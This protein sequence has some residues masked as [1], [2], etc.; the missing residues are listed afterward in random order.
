MT[1]NTSRMVLRLAGLMALGLS[2]AGCGMIGGKKEQTAS[3]SFVQVDAD[4]LECL[5]RAM[6]FESHRS[7]RDGLVA[8][9]NVVMN[10][11][12][13]DAYPDTI[14]GVVGQK[15]QFA[16]GVMTRPMTSSGLPTV[17]EAAISV[18]RGERHPMIGD[19]KFF[20]QAGHRFSYDNMNYVVT[21]GG[22]AFYE[23]RKAAY[24]TQ[25]VPLPPTEGLTLR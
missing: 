8:V 15:N 18:M 11:V 10:R 23:K 5:Q 13:S 3:R 4:D 6:F 20:H 24:V 1:M 12:K 25:P 17:Q 14:C 21:A 9:G 22:N 7:S 16:P 2:V 19:A